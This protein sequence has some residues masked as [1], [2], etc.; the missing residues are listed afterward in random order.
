MGIMDIIRNMGKDKEEFKQKFKDAEENIR[1]EKK[2]TERQKSSNERELEKYVEKQREENIRRRVEQIHK[3]QTRDSWKGKSILVK[4]SPIL[5]EGTS[6]L[7]NNQ[8]LLKS[9]SCFLSGGNKRQST[10]QKL[11]FN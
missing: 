9:N 2:L 6:I 5:N 4:G 8:K 7:T 3:K 11:Y 1:I 10:K